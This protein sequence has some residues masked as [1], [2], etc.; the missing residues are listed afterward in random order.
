MVL[1]VG[2]QDAGNTP[3]VGQLDRNIARRQARTRNRVVC[4]LVC[5]EHSPLLL[6]QRLLCKESW[7]AGGTE[8]E[9]RI[10]EIREALA[11]LAEKGTLDDV[12]SLLLRVPKTGILGWRAMDRYLD[13]L[14]LYRGDPANSS[15]AAID[16]SVVVLQRQGTHPVVIANYA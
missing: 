15:P 3:F 14:Y 2:R 16:K 9:V 5:Y 13:T 11:D 1:V 10:T 4:I 12:S 8:G 6:L 7:L